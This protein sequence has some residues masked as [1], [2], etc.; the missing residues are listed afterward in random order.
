MT[1]RNDHDAALLRIETLERENARL[2]RENAA[3]RTPTTPTEPDEQEPATPG[4]PP[5]IMTGLVL[6]TIVAIIALVATTIR[7]TPPTTQSDE[8]RITMPD[9]QPSG[10]PTNGE[11]P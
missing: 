4:R 10:F 5:R 1:Y 3:L 6:A 7:D 9:A 2:E 8:G 11:Q